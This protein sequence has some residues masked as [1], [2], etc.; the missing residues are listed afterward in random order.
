MGRML[1]YRLNARNKK[2]LTGNRQLFLFYPYRECAY[3]SAVN[4]P[5]TLFSLSA[6]TLVT[7]RS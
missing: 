6:G 7:S 2:Q 5:F 4:G 1:F 3:S